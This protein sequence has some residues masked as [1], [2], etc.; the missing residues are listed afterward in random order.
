LQVSRLQPA[1]AFDFH[2]S[3]FLKEEMAEAKPAVPPPNKEQA[4]VSPPRRNNVFLFVLVTTLLCALPFYMKT[5][6]RLDRTSI[7]MVRDKDKQTATAT[8]VEE[9]VNSSALH[10]EKRAASSAITTTYEEDDDN[11]VRNLLSHILV[12]IAYWHYPN[13]KG[14]EVKFLGHTLGTI[15]EWRLLPQVGN[16]TVVIVTNDADGAKKEIGNV[17]DYW[18][19]YHQVDVDDDLSFHMPFYHR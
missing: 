18:Y 8:D 9:D 10:S 19:T 7:S 16:V 17:N 15:R 1:L 14:E 4:V 12:T 6:R 2:I 11:E 13:N 5:I 3:Q